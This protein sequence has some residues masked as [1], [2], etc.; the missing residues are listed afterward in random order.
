MK[1]LKERL[2][3]QEA[4]Q[5]E[6][7]LERPAPRAITQPAIPTVD[8]GINGANMG[9]LKKQPFREFD[10]ARTRPWKYHNRNPA[11]LLRPE[12][13]SLEE[14]I[15]KHGQLEL[16]LV[17]TVEGVPGVDAEIVYGYR[18]SEACRTLSKKFRA[19]VLPADTS[20][21]ECMALMH[22][23]N[24]ESHDVSELED[25]RVYQRLLEDRVYAN[26]TEIAKSLNVSQVY[27]SRLLSTTPIFE[28]DW[29]LAVIEPV[30]VDMSVRTASTLA[31]GLKDPQTQRAMRNAARRISDS[32]QI[33]AANQLIT[34]LIGTSGGKRKTKS[35]KVVL[36]KKGRSNVAVLT[37]DASGN[38]DLSI[39]AHQQTPEE[40]EAL[41]ERIAAALKEHL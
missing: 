22:V 9:V 35:E 31:A 12:Q 33:I 16:G 41:I 10:V 24:K 27:V 26:Q 1:G 2:A 18:R 19:R 25:A 38:L 39:V 7:P 28:Y 29:L 34:E 15:R 21:T 13:R 11:W 14:S 17:R 5:G 37:H 3:E 36:R 4:K 40:R 8:V 30:I 20:D 6:T 23:E 32:G